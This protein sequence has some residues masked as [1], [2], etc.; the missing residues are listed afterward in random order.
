MRPHRKEKISSLIQAELGKI[1]ER[2][3][4]FDGAIVTV[5]AVEISDDLSQAKIKLGVFPKEEELAVLKVLE[6]E[7]RHLQFK[8]LRKINI[9]PMPTIK[10]EID[11]MAA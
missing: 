1:I 2:D 6:G 4:E 8:L 9:K 3:L 5:T 7:R 11:E 10:F